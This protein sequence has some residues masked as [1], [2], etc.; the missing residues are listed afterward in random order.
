M[1]KPAKTWV[2]ETCLTILYNDSGPG[3]SK[4]FSKVKTILENEVIIAGLFGYCKESLAGPIG[5]A[6]YLLLAR[7]QL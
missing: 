4:D 2:S 3:I 6:R 5:P 1:I 7:Q